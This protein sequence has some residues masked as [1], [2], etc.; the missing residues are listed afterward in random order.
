MKIFN[1]FLKVALAGFVVSGL[2]LSSCK[3]GD[4]GEPGPKGE[5]GPQGI[6]GIA[7]LNGKT[8]LSGTAAPTTA[9]GTEGDFYL[10]TATSDLYGPKTNT[11]WG[12][13]VSLKGA[14]GETGAAGTNGTNGKDGVNGKDGSAILTGDGAPAATLGKEG[15]FY[16]DRTTAFIYGPKTGQGWGAA[17]SLL[18]SYQPTMAQTILIKDQQFNKFVFQPASNDGGGFPGSW[19]A[20]L[21]VSLGEK[22]SKVY[23]EGVVLI[24][25]KD[26]SDVKGIWHD[27]FNS[28]IDIEGPDGSFG[29]YGGDEDS[30]DRNSFTIEGYY[31]RDN[32]SVLR[33]IKFD[34]KVVLIPSTLN[35]MAFSR[36]NKQNLAEVE[37]FLKMK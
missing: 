19:D 22:Y 14:K 6:Q 25:I 20:T 35:N 31:G 12:A 27:A 13:A 8:I 17:M 29:W 1:S 34:L 21:T 33:N 18:M 28:D 37:A 15:D 7:G 10:N 30:F 24:Y 36:V 26:K 2:L 32:E 9:V 11:G 3:K 4:Q 23:D 16:I 5:Q